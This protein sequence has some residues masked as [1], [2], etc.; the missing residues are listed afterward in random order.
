M[1]SH[2]MILA[3]ATTL[4]FGMYLPQALA[5]QAPLSATQAANQHWG[6]VNFQGQSVDFQQG[7]AQQRQQ[8]RPT[9]SGQRQPTQQRPGKRFNYTHLTAWVGSEELDETGIDA[10]A[11]RVDGAIQ[12]GDTSY[13]FASWQEADYEERGERTTREIGFGIQEQYSSRSSFF[14]ALG[15]LQDRWDQGEDGFNRDAINMLR[16]RYGMRAK[17]TDRIELDGAIVYTRSAGSSDM[18]SRWSLDVGLSIYLTDNV[19]L[20]AAGLDLD[21]IQPS[22]LFG[23]RV[24]FGN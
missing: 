15:Y 2:T 8:R 19:A 14:L 7:L 4:A 23:L 10:D 18:D 11:W 1:K 20:R 3:T 21:G 17:T 24:D 22:T 13:F 5:E 6:A 16:G 12:A 9:G